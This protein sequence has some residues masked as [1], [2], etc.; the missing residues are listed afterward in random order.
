M[1]DENRLFDT[2]LHM[3]LPQD[4]LKTVTTNGTYTVLL[5]SET[6]I[7][8]DDELMES[9]GVVHTKA[10]ARTKNA[11]KRL[12][13]DDIYQLY[14]VRKK[15]NARTLVPCISLPPSQRPSGNAG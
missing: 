14:H 9:A 6:Q 4:C 8:I 11:H 2:E 1:M 15:Q 12:A 10:L 5:L 7:N 3:M 13:T